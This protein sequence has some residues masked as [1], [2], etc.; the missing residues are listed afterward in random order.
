[1]KS[2]DLS[3]TTFGRLTVTGK[4]SNVGAKTCWRCECQCGQQAVVQTYLLTSGKTRS[5]GCLKSDRCREGGKKNK[6]HGEGHGGAQTFEYRSWLAMR[7]RC[8]NPR[9]KEY[10]SYGGRGIKICKRWDDYR[11]FLLDMGRRPS[12]KHSLERIDVNRGYTPSNC[13][14]ATNLEQQR[15]RRG[16]MYVVYKK[17]RVPVSELGEQSLVGVDLFRS[18]IQ[19]G[20]PVDRALTMPKSVRWSRTPQ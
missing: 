20:W 13:K 9:V 7:R 15:N 19:Q 18:R 3:G 8:L 4:A 14:W 16:T 1:M 6:V 10:P 5:C 11:F 17:K 2:A 12:P